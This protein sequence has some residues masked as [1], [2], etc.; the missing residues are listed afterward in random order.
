[1]TAHGPPQPAQA[2][3][4]SKPKPR[5]KRPS[6]PVLLCFVWPL[7]ISPDPHDVIQ[8][9]E[10][11]DV[12]EALDPF[13]QLL[14]CSTPTITHCLGTHGPLPFL[15]YRPMRCTRVLGSNWHWSTV[16]M[17]TLR[18]WRNRCRSEG[19]RV[20][21][22]GWPTRGGAGQPAPCEV[23]PMFGGPPSRVF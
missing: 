12:I 15:L 1:M 20:G 4:Y 19:W 5:D 21:P 22:I 23:G 18:R 10:P 17:Q 3:L 6:L 7:S 16:K 14:L 8:A 9:S 2:S 11:Y 13:A